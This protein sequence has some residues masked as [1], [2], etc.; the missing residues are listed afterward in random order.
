MARNGKQIESTMQDDFPLTITS[1]LAHGSRVF[2]QSECVT[3]QGDHARH[4]SYR[5]IEANARRL[6]Q[7]LTRLGVQP[8]DPVATTELPPSGAPVPAA[9]TPVAAMATAA[10]PAARPRR[11]FLRPPMVNTRIEPLRPKQGTATFPPTLKER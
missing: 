9:A 5:Q 11:R 2:G 10:A 7:A 3:W 4:T 1:I 6:A 8:G